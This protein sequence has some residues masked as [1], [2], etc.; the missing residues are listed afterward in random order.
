MKIDENEFVTEAEAVTYAQKTITVSL[1]ELSEQTEPTIQPLVQF[2]EAAI[3]SDKLASA[4]LQVNDAE[5]L[6]Q[7]QT[8]IINLPLTYGKNIHKIM[9]DDGEVDVNVYMIITAPEINRSKLWIDEL[10]AA[11]QLV[12]NPEQALRQFTDW[13]EAQLTTLAEN[14]AEAAEAD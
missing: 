10:M 13:V 1:A 3:N 9:V 4:N 11:D 7:L 8:S 5:V 14:Q 6:I 12:A 2:L